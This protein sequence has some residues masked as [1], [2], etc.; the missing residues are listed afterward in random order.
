[1]E[2]NPNG[3]VPKK[4]ILINIERTSMKYHNKNR[5]YLLPTNRQ[6][7]FMLQFTF[8]YFYHHSSNAARFV[9]TDCQYFQRVDEK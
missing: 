9:T 3:L 7:D 1:M 5:I 6:Y 8:Y 4:V 2:A